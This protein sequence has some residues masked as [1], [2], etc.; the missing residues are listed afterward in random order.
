MQNLV[1][2]LLS[3]TTEIFE[4]REMLL[5]QIASTCLYLHIQGN[6][7]CW[8]MQTCTMKYGIW[9][10]IVAS[11]TLILQPFSKMKLHINKN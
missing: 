6:L 10:I 11:V 8:E 2:S 4:H 5:E 1:N 3:E 7:N 9:S